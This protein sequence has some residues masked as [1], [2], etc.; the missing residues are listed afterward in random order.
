ME[1]LSPLEING[2][3]KKNDNSIFKSQSMMLKDRE[4][5]TPQ[6][7][8]DNLLDNLTPTNLNNIMFKST[9]RLENSQVRMNEEKLQKFLQSANRLSESN[10]IIRQAVDSVNK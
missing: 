7:I 3:S 2:H 4:L 10:Q 6:E 5:N 8:K 1:A 9:N